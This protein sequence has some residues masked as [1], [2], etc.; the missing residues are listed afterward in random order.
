MAVFI[1]YG[2]LEKE[3]YNTKLNQTDWVTYNKPREWEYTG[4]QRIITKVKMDLLKQYCV[5]LEERARTLA[6]DNQQTC[7][8]LS[9]FDKNSV[10][11][12]DRLNFW[13]RYGY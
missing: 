12:Q 13:V 2:V 11:Y 10:E 4:N 1:D 3:I 5:K 7:V 9:I 8:Y 6:S